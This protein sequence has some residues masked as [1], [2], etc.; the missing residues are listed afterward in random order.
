[1]IHYRYG[2]HQLSDKTV[3]HYCPECGCNMKS[4]T[5]Y[6]IKFHE[7]HCSNKCGV[8]KNY[9]LSYVGL[10]SCE[11]EI[12]SALGKMDIRQKISLIRDLI[13]EQ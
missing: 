9:G 8:C 7:Q 13:N 3:Y 10:T 1:M 6:G 5:G 2:H 4:E 12:F 11:H